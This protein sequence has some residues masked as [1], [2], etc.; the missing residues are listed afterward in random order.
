MFNRRR[1]IRVRPHVRR[2]TR[3]ETITLYDDVTNK[4]TTRTI[5]IPRLTREDFETL[6]NVIGPVPDV[7]YRLCGGIEKRGWSENDIDICASGNRRQFNNRLRRSGLHLL[8]KGKGYSQ[9]GEPIPDVWSWKPD[10]WD[11]H[12]GILIDV[13]WES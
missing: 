11:W 2:I 7:T 12:E 5:E 13:F 3:K 10:N 4:P 1:Q 9:M 6:A 8:E